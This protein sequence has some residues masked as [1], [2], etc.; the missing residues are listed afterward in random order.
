M[1]MERQRWLLSWRRD[2]GLIRNRLQGSEGTEYIRSL[3]ST[4]RTTRAFGSF[5]RYIYRKEYKTIQGL[6]LALVTTISRER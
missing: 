4:P 3:N 5:G 6:Q 1:G 2:R